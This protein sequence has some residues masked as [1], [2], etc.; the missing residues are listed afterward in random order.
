MS[1]SA[2]DLLQV[3]NYIRS[4]LDPSIRITY[5]PRAKKVSQSGFYTKTSNH[6]YSQRITIF[7]TKATSI[8]RLK[9]IDQVPVSEDSSITVTL[10]S[11]ALNLPPTPATT[12]KRN[13]TP[14]P[15]V[16]VSE[17][18]VAQW[19]GAD[20]PNCDMETLG[21]DGKFNWVC[22]VPSQGKINLL[23]QWEVTSPVHAHI[24]GL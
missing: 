18:V 19:D 5:H 4:S 11:P 3:L 21:K 12:I 23:L 2:C 9:V 13:I 15:P 8:E 24:V 6:I 16:T 22:S 20:E 1:C 17:G 10:N 7:N 14:P